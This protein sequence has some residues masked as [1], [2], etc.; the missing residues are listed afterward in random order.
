M[1]TYVLPIG[2][3]M[4]N[5]LQRLGY[6]IDT[7]M[8]VID[9]LF[10]NHKDDTDDSLFKSVPWKTYMKQLEEV[11]VEYNEAKDQLTKELI[12]FVQEKE[13]KQDVHFDWKI[14]DFSTKEVKIIVNDENLS[15]SGA[16]CSCH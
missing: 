16:S 7:R 12:P 3:E 6:E 9:R 11:Q 2:E 5:Y 4:V 13:G 15:C 10:V 14:E 8:S 1:K